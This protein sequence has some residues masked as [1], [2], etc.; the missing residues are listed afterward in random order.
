MIDPRLEPVL[1]L[2]DWRLVPTGLSDDDAIRAAVA[3]LDLERL[4]RRTMSEL[5]PGLAALGETL[6]DRDAA[7]SVIRLRLLPLLPD[8]WGEIA[9]TT[10]GEMLRFEGI[11]VNK[12]RALIEFAA[13]R[14]LTTPPGRFP[15]SPGQ[16]APDNEETLSALRSIAAWGVTTGRTTLLES[17]VAAAQGGSDSPLEALDALDRMD[18]A[19]FAGRDLVRSAG[20][21]QIARGILDSL[22]ER[23]RSILER[24][25][26]QLDPL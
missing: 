20:P 4:R 14:T 6:V 21:I 8:T 12:V 23:D 25:I 19:A 1:P 24:R 5:V 26:L 15:R 22:T 16:P 3:T 18:L 11:G 7:P 13:H 2:A 9:Q 17:L 10:I